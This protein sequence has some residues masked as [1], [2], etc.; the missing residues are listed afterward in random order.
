M[1][2]T[3]ET[4]V[5]GDAPVE[6]GD[7]CLEG[8]GSGQGAHGQRAFLALRQTS[9]RASKVVVGMLTV[10]VHSE[11]PKKPFRVCTSNPP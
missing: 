8:R 10:S 5:G 2:Q 3:R 11:A 7:E 1:P 4:D 6:A 9:P